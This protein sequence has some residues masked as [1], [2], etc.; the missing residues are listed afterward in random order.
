MTAVCHICGDTKIRPLVLCKACGVVPLPEERALAWL[1]GPEHLSEVE[2]K[3]VAVRIR[4]GEV[5]LPS[6]SLQRQALYK[7][8]F[9]F[10]RNAYSKKWMVGLFVAN[11]LLTPLIGVGIWWGARMDRPVLAT[12]SLW[13]SAIAFTC[14]TA[15]IWGGI[16][17]SRW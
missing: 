12:Q 9:S 10:T 5:L 16:L 15:M 2:R 6:R 17:A 11:F 7:L 14:S 8:G 4:N 13:S 3:E 1:L